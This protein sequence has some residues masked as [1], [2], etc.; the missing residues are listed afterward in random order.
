M[1]G[2]FTIRAVAMLFIIC[3]AGAA[4]ADNTL[5]GDGITALRKGA[6]TPMPTADPCILMATVESSGPAIDIGWIEWR[7]EEILDLSHPDD[8]DCSNPPTS[9]TIEGVF[10]ITAEHGDE[11]F[12]VYQGVAQIDAQA[13][14]IKALGHYQITGGS[15]SFEDREGQ[16]IT[17]ISGRFAPPFDF[18]GE[19]IAQRND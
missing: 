18:I 11:I 19:L 13:A 7:S 3:F 14:T 17:A 2:N 1:P 5:P 15:G 12:G 8:P 10:V 16:G 4:L 6:A 9:A